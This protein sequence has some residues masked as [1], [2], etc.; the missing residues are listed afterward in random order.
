MAERDPLIARGEPGMLPRQK[1]AQSS[2]AFQSRQGIRVCLAILLAVAVALTVAL[3]ID[4][5]FFD[6]PN[7]V[8]ASIVVVLMFAL[9][10]HDFYGGARRHMR[11]IAW[12]VTISCI[13]G[14]LIGFTGYFR[15]AVFY[16]AA[17]N[18]ATYSDASAV[19]P[20]GIFRDASMIT[21][22]EFTRV[23]HGRGAGYKDVDVAGDVHCV[24]P[25]M[26]DSQSA[27]DKVTFWAVGTNCCADGDHHRQFQCH[28]AG[29]PTAHGA[30]VLLSKEFLIPRFFHF[31]LPEAAGEEAHMQALHLQNDFFG[32]VSSETPIFVRWVRDPLRYVEGYWWST[33]SWVFGGTFLYGVGVFFA[34]F[35][36]AK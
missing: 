25:V 24:A 11:A 33:L 14:T 23:Q 17:I 28:D 1:I 2:R 4:F 32:D 35:H 36:F 19:E 20:G 5:F 15:Y 10:M 21:F 30:V 29:D 34:A 31:L 7:W 6:H 22:N 8:W 26:A 16:R 18:M 3:A 12:V 27:H 9:I 13:V